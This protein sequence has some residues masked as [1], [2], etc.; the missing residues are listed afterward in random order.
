M[1]KGLYLCQN[2]GQVNT[3]TISNCI[4]DLIY[5]RAIDVNYGT[6]IISTFNSYN[7]VANNYNGTLN[8]SEYIIYFGNYSSGCASVNDQFDRSYT[9]NL[10]TPWISGNSSSSGW[11]S[12][13]SLRLGY[14]SQQGG[15]TYSLLANKTNEPVGITYTI[16]DN[17][18]NQRIQYVIVRDTATR[19]GVLQLVYNGTTKSY[20][21]D[22]EC[23]ET[24]DVGVTFRLTG[25][26]TTLRL[27]YTS[28][29]TASTNFTLSTAASNIKTVW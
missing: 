26:G 23:A 20:N 25:D 19:S 10:T 15:S 28:T 11:F 27:L 14:F 3:M 22:E 1:Y 7:D 13:Y 17:T 29:S 8:P 5:S 2:G 18:F 6:N 24:A 12:G 9:Q 16:L 21:I 4:F